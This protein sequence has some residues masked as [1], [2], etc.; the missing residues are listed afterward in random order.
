VTFLTKCAKKYSNALTY[1]AC[2]SVTGLTGTGML[3]SYALDKSYNV[4][5]PIASLYLLSICVPLGLLGHYYVKKA[6]SRYHELREEIELHGL[7]EPLLI[8]SAESSSIRNL[9]E[10]IVEEKKL[11]EQYKNRKKEY[12]ASSSEH[13]DSSL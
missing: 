1:Y 7:S 4:S 5:F 13:S 10:I 11:T 3:I 6:K 9:V 8:E 2:A 12:E